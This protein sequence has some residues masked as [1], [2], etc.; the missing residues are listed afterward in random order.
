TRRLLGYS[1]RAES[2]PMPGVLRVLPRLGPGAIRQRAVT[3]QR[4]QSVRFEVNGSIRA[5]VELGYL[6]TGQ[7]EHPIGSARLEVERPKLG[8]VRNDLQWRDIQGAIGGE[9]EL[10]SPGRS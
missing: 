3:V 9:R 5:E 4:V 1:W 7:R 2:F 8:S 10:G 6:E